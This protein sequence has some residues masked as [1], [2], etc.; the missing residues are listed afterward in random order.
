MSATAIDFPK[1]SFDKVCSF[2]V[3]EHIPDPHLFFTQVKKVLKPDGF[4]IISFPLEFIRGQ[5]AI[6]DSINVYGDL[7]HTRLL[8]LH[9]LFPKK[10]TAIANP[11]GFKTISS[12]L[13]LAPFPTYLMI[14]KKKIK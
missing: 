2:E 5:T 6:L 9:K 1:N 7:R 3:I 14:F 4:L 13:V 10:I 12:K 11:L 8:H